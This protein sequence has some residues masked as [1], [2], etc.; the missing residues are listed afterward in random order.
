VNFIQETL[1]NNDGE[2]RVPPF[3]SLMWAMVHKRVVQGQRVAGP[4]ESLGERR[5]QRCLSTRMNVDVSDRVA[6]AVAREVRRADE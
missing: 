4:A 1:R 2:P 3:L 6:A 5:Q